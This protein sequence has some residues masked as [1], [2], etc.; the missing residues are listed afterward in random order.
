ME[1]KKQPEEKRSTR[2]A[3]AIG[4][5]IVESET[6]DLESIANLS[7]NLLKNQ[8]VRNYLDINKIQKTKLQGRPFG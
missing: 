8:E 6:E 1:K 3:I 7:V 5:L 4:S 2:N